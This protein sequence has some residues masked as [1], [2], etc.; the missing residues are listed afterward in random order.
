MIT[1]NYTL[2]NQ[3]A[4]RIKGTWQSEIG[5]GEFNVRVVLKEGLVDVEAT[6]T[7]IINFLKRITEI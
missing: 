1:L 2:S 4:S 3:Q 6:E 5:S 7:R